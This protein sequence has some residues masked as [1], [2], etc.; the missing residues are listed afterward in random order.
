MTK[1]NV[2]TTNMFI[3]DGRSGEETRFPLGEEE[4]EM[5]DMMKE[6]T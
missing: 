5:I 6:Q 3:S 4:E 2:F 1:L